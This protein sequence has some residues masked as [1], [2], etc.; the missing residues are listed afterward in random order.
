MIFEAI[1]VISFTFICLILEAKFG[2]DLLPNSVQS[3]QTKEMNETYLKHIWSL[4]NPRAIIS[5]FI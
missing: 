1:E 5:R 2:E 3:D 4:C